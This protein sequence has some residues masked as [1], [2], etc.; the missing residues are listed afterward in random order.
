M[1]LIDARIFFWLEI[2]WKGKKIRFKVLFLL[3]PCRI[4]GIVQN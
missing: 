1:R 3:V 2:N 4:S